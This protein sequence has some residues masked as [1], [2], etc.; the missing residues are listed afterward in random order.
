MRFRPL[1]ETGSAVSAITLTLDATLAALGADK[2][3]EIVYAALEEGIN[4]FFLDSLD[5][6][7]IRTAG[8]AL[9]EVER[10]LLK[11]ALTVGPLPNGRRDFSTEGLQAV[12][13]AV[14]N[15]SGLEYFDLLVLDDPAQN[16][17]PAQSLKYLRTE[18][19]IRRLGIRG[20]SQVME[21]YVQSGRF[22]VLLT[23]CH[24][25]LDAL[26]RSS[27]RSAREADMIIYGTDYYPEALLNPVKPVA[28]VEQAKGLF[29]LVRK[30]PVVEEPSNPFFFLHRTDGWE[31]EEL[32][33]AHALLNP[34][35]ATVI[36]RTTQ[37]ERLQRLAKTCE[38]DMPVSL[39]AQLEMAR[40]AATR[41]A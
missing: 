16:E 6:T 15:A 33:L 20:S 28:I 19:S 24:I 41:A 2:V 23:P 31:A 21:T 30:K 37:V 32:C 13:D 29:S 34:S 4:S 11:V 38:R 8:E 3:R 17:L 36:V 35:L 26:Q 9:R 25:Q 27:M 7:L 40:V 14:L 39:P 10:D 1:G 18:A 5:P 12:L 22:D